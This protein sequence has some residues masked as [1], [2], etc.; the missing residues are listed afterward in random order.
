MKSLSVLLLLAVGLIDC[1]PNPNLQYDCSGESELAKSVPVAKPMSNLFPIK[2]G[3]HWIFQ[4]EANG[5]YTWFN[6]SAIQ[7]TFGCSPYSGTTL[8][9]HITKS[10][11][12]AYWNPGFDAEIFQPEVDD[13]KEIWSPGFYYRHGTGWTTVDLFGSETLPYPYLP[14]VF[15]IPGRMDSPYR[16]RMAAGASLGCLPA[17]SD[18]YHDPWTTYWYAREVSTPVYSG[19]A[20]ASHQCEALHSDFE[21]VWLFAPGVGLVEIDALRQWG[22]PQTP[23][24]VIKRQQDQ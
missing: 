7:G 17:T 22:I 9:M 6:F 24:L 12:G 14:D 21:E 5:D 13:G 4:N 23:P 19:I 1:A 10:A 15:S 8:M 11:V 18:G 16:A 3:T 2:D 20:I